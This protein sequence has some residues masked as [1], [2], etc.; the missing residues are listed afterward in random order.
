LIFVNIKARNTIKSTKIFA[1]T[2][3]NE[4]ALP[5]EAGHALVA[6]PNVCV[7]SL[8]NCECARLVVYAEHPTLS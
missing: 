7:C 2:S 4:A 5:L 6:S 8:M 3:D 1:F